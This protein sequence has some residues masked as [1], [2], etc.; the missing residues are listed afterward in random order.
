MLLHLINC[1]IIIIIIIIIITECL[2]TQQPISEQR[3]CACTMTVVYPVSNAARS[4]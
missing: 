3:S 2:A 1:I 4:Q